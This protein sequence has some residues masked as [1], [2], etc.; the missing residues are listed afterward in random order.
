LSHTTIL[1]FL[2]VHC[3]IYLFDHTCNH[4][5]TLNVALAFDMLID[6]NTFTTYVIASR[7]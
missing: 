6:N 4:N 2:S 3:D 7:V 1:T 5:Y